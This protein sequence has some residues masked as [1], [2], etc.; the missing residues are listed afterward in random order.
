MSA[1]V[2][3]GSRTVASSEQAVVLANVSR[4]RFLQGMSL[5]GL[6]TIAL[7]DHAPELVRSAVLVDV[8]PG[9]TAEKSR[10]ITAFVNGP[11]VCHRSEM[12]QGVDRHA[13]DRRGRASRPTGS[14]CASPRRPV[15]REEVRQPDTDGSRSTPPFLRADALCCAP[16]ARAMPQV[17]AAADRWKVPVSEV[18]AKNH[19]VVHSASGRRPDTAR[20]RRPRRRPARC[21]RGRA[22]LKDRRLPPASAGELKLV[23]AM[24]IATGKAQVRHDT[25][26]PGMLYAVVARPPVLGGKVASVDDSAAPRCPV[27]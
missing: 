4:R 9:V 24:D 1:R 21:R 25:R 19:E 2:D 20:S 17:A 13:D 18:A 23:D 14:E 3:R 15:T 16:P 26:L 10:F 11:D 7:A 22:A 12:G 6:T 5:G 8:T 27:W